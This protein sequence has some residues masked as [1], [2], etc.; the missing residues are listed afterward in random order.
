MSLDKEETTCVV[1]SANWQC[2][3]TDSLEVLSVMINKSRTPN[4]LSGHGMLHGKLLQLDWRLDS[5]AFTL[6]SKDSN[7]LGHPPTVASPEQVKHTALPLTDLTS[8][9]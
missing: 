8:R 1:L 3:Q 7:L 2:L 9:G 6:K 4:Q 5:R